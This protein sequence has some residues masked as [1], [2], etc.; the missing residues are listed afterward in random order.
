MNFTYMD[1][2]FSTI[3]C[4]LLLYFTLGG[5]KLEFVPPVFNNITRSNNNNITTSL[6][7]ILR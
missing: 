6:E 5:T 3:Y 2:M 4:L 7:Q 1:L